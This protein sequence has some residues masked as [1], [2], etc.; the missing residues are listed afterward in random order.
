ME[1]VKNVNR[2]G[3]SAGILLP[4]EWIGNQVKVVLIDRTNEIKKEVFSIL[5]S[6]FI[7]LLGVYLVGS[8][9]RGDYDESSDIDIIAI[10]KDT[11]KEIISGRY[12]VSITPL[13]SLK[14][15]LEKHPEL[16][17]PRFLEA[18]TIFNPL[19]SEEIISFKVNKDSF[20]EFY[21]DSKRI[22]KINKGLVEIDKNNFGK[23]KSASVIYSLLLRLKGV[24]LIK[25]I[26]NKERYSKRDFKNF[27]LEVLKEQEFQEV[28]KVY[29]TEK[30]GKKTA[31]IE[32]QILVTEKLIELLEKELKILR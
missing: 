5:E 9:A 28:Y 3:N 20:K 19:L 1:I 15:T 16:V 18:K 8:Y 12:N 4:K 2:W 21:K 24:F 31:K 25:C 7:D 26:L 29:S 10:S 32:V 30:D 27:L 6:Y 17:L 14:K 11:K 23:L 13:N 22:L